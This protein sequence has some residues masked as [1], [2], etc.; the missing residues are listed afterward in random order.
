MLGVVAS[1]AGGVEGLLDGLIRPALAAGWR[2]GVTL[3]PTAGRWLR[4]AGLV[5]EIEQATGLPVRV[6]S[7]LPGEAKPHPPVDCYVVAPATATT[8]AKL[9]LGLGDNQA[10]TQVC[11]AIGTRGVSVVVFP[12]VN[13]A[14]VR[15]PAWAGHVAALRSA[16]VDLVYGEDVWPLCEPRTGEFRPLPWAAVLA[17]VA[18]TRSVR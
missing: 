9:A 10:L 1:G 13:A 3:T 7:R 16:G 17:A 11:E 14:H 15:H 2:V 8:V 5:A 4:E 12:C 6:E 18:A